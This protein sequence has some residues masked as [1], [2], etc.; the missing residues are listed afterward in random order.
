EFKTRP[1]NGDRPMKKEGNVFTRG[2]DRRSFLQRGVLAGGVVAVG[3]GLMSR[4]ARAFDHDQDGDDRLTPGDAAILRFALAA[5]L[6]EADLWTQY[7]ELGG[8]TPGQLPLETLQTPPLN[9]YQSAFLNLDGDGPQYISSN[10]LDEVSH[11]AFL[12]AYLESK[13]AESVNFDKF[14]TLQGSQ[15]TGSTGIGR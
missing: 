15:A 5:E 1:K 7:A 4:D 9:S 14:R 8:L 10:T 11:A 13:G 12:S 2:T 6:I 3:A